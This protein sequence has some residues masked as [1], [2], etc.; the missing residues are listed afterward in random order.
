MN[1]FLNQANSVGFDIAVVLS[2]FAIF[3]FGIKSMGDSLKIVAGSRMKS[4]IDRS[5]TNPVMGVFVGAF[6]TGL[7]QSSSGTTALAISLVRAGLMNLK[8]AVGII[9]GANI[10]TTITAILIGF[11][12]SAYSPYILIV[13]AFMLM[14]SQK[15]KWHHIAML[16][17]SFGALFFGLEMMGSGLKI[18]AKMPLFMDFTIRLA[19]N[20]VLGILLGAGMTIVIQSSSA[21]IGILQTLYGDNLITLEGALPVLFGDNI[22]TTITAVLASIGGSVAAKRAAAA[23]VTFNV[24]GTL[25]FLIIFPV[26]FKIVVTASDYFDL[27]RAMQIAFAHA[28]FNVS[29]TLLLLPFISIIVWFVTKLIKDKNADEDI[30]RIILD[31]KLLQISPKDAVTAAYGNAVSMANLCKKISERTQLY[32]FER[33]F[34]ARDKAVIFE[35]I[36]N[37]YNRDI[38]KYLI[39]IGEAELDE[40]YNQLQSSLL[41]CIK[42]LERIA[43]HFINLIEDFD[44]VFSAKESLTDAAIS[45]LKDMF[46]NVDDVIDKVILLLDEYDEEL[47]NEV[48]TIEDHID[49]LNE[50]AKDNFFARYKSG[51]LSKQELTTTLYVDI[52]SELERIGDHCE[53]IAVRTKKAHN[54]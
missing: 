14:F 53:N 18:L 2:G 11:K 40:E 37:D 38:A 51:V 34:K 24:I 35:E 21:T 16:I 43:D 50:N 22:G 46:K 25:I 4:I 7:L 39:K 54:S 1:E 3:L 8:Q 41:Y 23:H 27:N 9:M 5:T 10:G 36:V 12:I 47:V 13:G 29:T 32:I 44:E 20:K 33:N 15:T 28:T 31:E 26:F 30:E 52:L 19:E 6:V 45:E 42:D 17:F 48:I 49:E